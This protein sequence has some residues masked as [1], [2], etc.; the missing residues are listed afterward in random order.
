[1]GLQR[2]PPV[3]RTASAAEVSSVAD[4]RQPRSPPSLLAAVSA[5]FW[6]RWRSPSL[7]PRRGGRLLW[8][9]RSSSWR[10]S[11]AAVL[12]VFADFVACVLGGLGL[13]RG[14]LGGLHPSPWSTPACGSAPPG[15]RRVWRGRWVSVT[16]SRFVEQALHPRRSERASVRARPRGLMANGG[17]YVLAERVDAPVEHGDGLH[18]APSAR[19]RSG[20]WVWTSF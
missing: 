2:T 8:R 12:V 4:L 18:A 9:Q 11:F 16:D 13:G 5:V 7:P 20:R 15:S 1:M 14:G 17:P 19:S 10:T 6:Q 3:T